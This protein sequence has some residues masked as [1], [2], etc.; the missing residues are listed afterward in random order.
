MT[1]KR[2]TVAFALTQATYWMSYSTA[3]GFAAV[4]LQSLGCT[5]TWVGLVLAAGCLAGTLLGALL[6]DRLDRGLATPAG[7]L[8]VLLLGQII[9]SLY[10]LAVPSPAG[11][12]VYVL[13]TLYITCAIGVNSPDMKVYADLCEGGAAIPFG[14]CR[15]MGSV[16]CVIVSLG[17]GTSIQYIS[18]RALPFIALVLA[19]L[20]WIVR[21]SIYRHPSVGLT[22]SRKA[23]G[24]SLPRFISANRRYCVLLLGLIMIFF[25]YCTT[26]NFRI[27]IVREVGGD[28]AQMGV[29]AAYMVV[30]EVPVMLLYGKYSHKWNHVTLLRFSFVCFILRITAFALAS[31]MWQLY[32]AGTFQAASYALY[33]A[34]IVPYVTAVTDHR[35]AAKAQNLAFSVITAGSLLASLVSGALLDIMS[36]HQVLW[37]VC[38]VCITGALTAFLALDTKKVRNAAAAKEN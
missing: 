21:F 24:V 20:G 13:Y 37:I 5:N 10:M 14:V 18:S 34:S 35:D 12:V 30:T 25:A 8:P 4:Y 2:M 16:G 9:P 36:V 17:V 26:N 27:N 7:L 6:S 31:S 11:A 1:D 19:V 33:A 22:G 29:L 32:V 23:R 28:T 38:A 15:A 3:I